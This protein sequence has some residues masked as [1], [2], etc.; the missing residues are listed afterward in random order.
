MLRWQRFSMPGRTS[1]VDQASAIIKVMEVAPYAPAL[2]AHGHAIVESA[3]FKGS[4]RSQEFLL[5]IIEKA[6]DGRFD[7]L[8]ERTIGAELFGRSPSYDTGQDAVVRVT[9]SDVRKRLLQFYGEIGISSELRVDL[10]PG[11]YIP[12]FRCIPKVSAPSVP[13][14]V[15]ETAAVPD[16]LKQR[17]A[18]SRPYMRYWLVCSIVSLV[19]LAAVW[20]LTQRGSAVQPSPKKILPWSAIFRRDQQVQVVL[21]DPDISSVQ[22]L[23]DFNISLSDYANRRYA[24]VASLLDESVK[25][26]F[27][28]FHGANVAAVDLGIVLSI[29]EL[30]SAASQHLKIH[31]AR[32]LQLLDFKN[33][34]NFILLGSPRSNP[35]VERFSDQ[36]D[37]TFVY[38]Q[39]LKMG[40]VRNKRVQPGELAVYVPTANGWDTG[41]AYA[42]VALV[43]NPNQN[44]RVALLAGSNAE[45]TEAAGKLSTNLELL[46]RILKS[47]GIDPGGAPQPFEVLLHVSIMAGSSNTFDVIACHRLSGNP[48][49]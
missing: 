12:E 30:A 16:E 41:H 42:I 20:L 9:A 34:D 4:R 2:R 35:W 36:L 21:A 43:A 18:R 48:L 45:A 27:Q 15:P 26:V 5:Y 17:S 3:A 25:R 47:H 38:D 49:P 37:F 11:S 33:D 7:E 14:A 31:T 13:A 23:L 32:S 10:P 29:S 24:P 40:V 44:G 19:I 46:S 22:R 6:L 28:S 8:K 1:H 39:A